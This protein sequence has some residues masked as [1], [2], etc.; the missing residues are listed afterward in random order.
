MHHLMFQTSFPRV[1]ISDISVGQSPHSSSKQRPQLGHNIIERVIMSL[2][3]ED[4][5]EKRD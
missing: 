4:N 2:D 1:H 5:N 3:G